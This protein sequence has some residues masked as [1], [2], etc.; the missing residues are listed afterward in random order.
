M[1]QLLGFSQRK[2]TV[3]FSSR[4]LSEKEPGIYTPMTELRQSP[5]RRL[6]PRS[7]GA[8]SQQ[9]ELG[10]KGTRWCLSGHLR[11]LN[12]IRAPINSIPK[13]FCLLWGYLVCE[14]HRSAIPSHWKNYQVSN[15]RN[16][17]RKCVHLSENKLKS[18]YSTS[19]RP[20]VHAA[21]ERPHNCVIKHPSRHSKHIVLWMFTCMYFLSRFFLWN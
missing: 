20:T 9:A 13:L 3:C 7:N 15:Y 5:G 8:P 19:S 6:N 16:P 21:K 11:P 1:G 4:K 12:A 14:L 10:S 18:S 2:K 17:L